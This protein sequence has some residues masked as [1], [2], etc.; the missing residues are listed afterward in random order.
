MFWKLF[1]FD[2]DL[3]ALKMRRKA[4]TWPRSAFAVR[5]TAAFRDLS[6]DRRNAGLDLFEDKGMLLVIDGG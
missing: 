3:D 5:A 2:H 4:L 1:R 6:L